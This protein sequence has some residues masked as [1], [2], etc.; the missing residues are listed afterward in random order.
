M[1]VVVGD[2]CKDVFIY[3]D[4]KRI[5]P[6]APVP[7]FNPSPIDR[8]ENDG[9]A[10]NVV[11]N[12][13]ALGGGDVVFFKPVDVPIKTRYVDKKSN[14]M[15]LRIDESDTCKHIT[16]TELRQIKK[17]RKLTNAVVISDYNK[18]FL[19]EEDIEQIASFFEYSFLDTKKLLGSWVDDITFIKLNKME[20]EATKHTL[21]YI[22]NIDDKLIVTLGQDGCSYQGK[23]Y[24]VVQHSTIDVSGAGD[25]FHAAFFLQYMRTKN[26]DLSINYAQSC[27]EVVIR[28]KGVAVR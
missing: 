28:K 4:C 19:Q 21:D 8:I 7:V 17:M 1:I 2:N 9:M 27:T 6:E 14:Q 12:I 23:R 5:C 20:Y 26:V 15:L 13:E 25:T 11:R 3:G 22:K 18:G 24:S 16:K 10:G